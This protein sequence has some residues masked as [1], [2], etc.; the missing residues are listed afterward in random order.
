MSEETKNRFADWAIL[1]LMGH[2]RLAGFVQE[3]ELAGAGLLRIDIPS[4]PPV[5]QFYGVS[6]VY[7]LTPTT[8]EIA[9]GLARSVSVQPVH[10]YELPAAPGTSEAICDSCE[11]VIMPGQPAI[12]LPGG[13]L[14]C[15]DCCQCELDA[16]YADGEH[17][18]VTHRT[19]DTGR[20]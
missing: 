16:N 13:G 2:R 5:T 18:E 19:D 3:A 6:S 4:A 11:Q 20:S 17:K 7:C 14:R 10:P 8:E 1:E 12:V 9:R 15:T